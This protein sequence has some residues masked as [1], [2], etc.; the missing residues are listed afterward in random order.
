MSPGRNHPV[1]GITTI[2][3]GG[4]WYHAAA[5]YDGYDL[6]ALPD[7]QLETELAVGQPVQSQS[8]QHAAIASALDHDRRPPRASS[9]ASSTR[10]ASGTGRCTLA[11]TPAQ[12]QRRAHRAADGSRG[13]LGP[14]RG[15][16]DLRQQQRRDDRPGDDH[17]DR[18]GLGDPGGSVRSRHQRP[19]EPADAGRARRRR[20]RACRCRRRSRSRRPTPRATRSRSSFCGRPVPAQQADDFTI[21]MIPDT[22]YY[23]RP[24]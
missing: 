23:T 4:S 3:T 7:G 12:H 16:R 10:C 6:A 14:E 19:A 5:T 13:A 15:D 20:R 1:I 21:L 22:Q 2:Q 9:T 24:S 18:L 8:V 11:E 17:R